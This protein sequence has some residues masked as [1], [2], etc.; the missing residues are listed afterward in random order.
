MYA[1]TFTF[2]F[3]HD[4]YQIPDTRYQILPMPQQ[5]APC[6]HPF[7]NN[8][9]HP[10]AMSHHTSHGCETKMPLPFVRVYF[11]FPLLWLLCSFFP[12]F[13]CIPMQNNN[14]NDDDDDG[15]GYNTANPT[16]GHWNVSTSVCC[17]GWPATW[18]PK[19]D[20]SVND[21]EKRLNWRKS[22]YLSIELELELELKLTQHNISKTTSA[23]T[24]HLSIVLCKQQHWTK[25]ACAYAQI[26]KCTNAQMRNCANLKERDRCW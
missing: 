8:M 17:D 3:R 26:H 2:T 9:H 6:F 14:N 7:A 12:W 18:Q 15:Y 16:F 11:N 1:T 5:H 22:I 13:Q 21:L 23:R 20:R 25:G 4:K 24:M 19:I 10:K